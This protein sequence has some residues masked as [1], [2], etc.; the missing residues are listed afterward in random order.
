MK[1]YIAT[2]LCVYACMCDNVHADLNKKKM[3]F[4]PIRFRDLKIYH[5]DL[6]RIGCIQKLTLNVEKSVA[7]SFIAALV[8]EVFQLKRFITQKLG[9]KLE[10]K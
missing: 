10:I 1:A 2:F 5:G 7:A 6:N 3:P 9:I 8:S 4:S